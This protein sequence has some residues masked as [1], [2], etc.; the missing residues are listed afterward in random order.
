M[1]PLSY[2]PAVDLFNEPCK[3]LTKFRIELD[4]EGLKQEYNY[5]EAHDL[6]NND[7]ELWRKEEVETIK[8]EFESVHPMFHLVKTYELAIRFKRTLGAIGR[9]KQ[10][11]FSNDPTLH[12]NQFAKEIA[13]V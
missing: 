10:H 3:A 5:L 8:E 7:W 4:L 6:L 13:N 12:R 2:E 1:S 11:V 9:Q